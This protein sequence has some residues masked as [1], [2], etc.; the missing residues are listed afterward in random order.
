LALGLFSESLR[1]I[2][3][4]DTT[5][6]KKLPCFLGI[7]T[8]KQGSRPGLPSAYF[9]LTSS[10]PE[11]IKATWSQQRKHQKSNSNSSIILPELPLQHNQLATMYPLQPLLAFLTLACT[12]NASST[13][14][15]ISKILARAPSDSNATV[16]SITYS[17]SGCPTSDSATVIWN[18]NAT[19][20]FDGLYVYSSD[21][22][23]D[24]TVQCTTT[25]DISLDPAWRYGV[26]TL[27]TFRGYLALPNGTSLSI[28]ADYSIGNSSVGFFFSFLRTLA[29]CDE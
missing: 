17:G 27:T 2:S 6:E 29:F 26:G 19:I 11:S 21:N 9:N 25:I 22:P 23:A 18:Y 3:S 4:H 7:G 5:G 28:Q 1:Y 16:N 14:Q 24:A 20:A 13:L 8:R 15:T 10:G 12:I